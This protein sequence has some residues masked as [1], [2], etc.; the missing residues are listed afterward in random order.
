M[1]R[2][3]Q[4]RPDQTRPDQTRPDHYSAFYSDKFYEAHHSDIALISAYK[5]VKVVRKYL[6]FDSVIDIGCGGGQVLKACSEA[7]SHTIHGVDGSWVNKDLLLIPS[8]CFSQFDISQPD[9][10]EK[11]PQKRFDLTVSSEVAEHIDPCDTDVFMDNLTSFSDVVLF[12]AA[13]PGQGG[14]HHVNEQWPSY[15]IEKFAARGF[16]PVDCIRPEI[17]DDDTM[18]PDYRQNLMLFVRKT[19]LANYPAISAEA[20]RKVLNLVHPGIYMQKIDAAT[21]SKMG[22]RA[23][24]K[25]IPSAIISLI[26]SLI[27]SIKK[28]I[29]A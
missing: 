21:P 14:T 5:A 25:M 8:E 20:G 23:L 11:I 16:I 3:D 28:R 29:R 6:D 10:Q 22:T 13:I 9:L 26:P 27:R 4:T 7:G 24:C 19:Q 12:S 17:W 2:P 15:W 1:T 18:R